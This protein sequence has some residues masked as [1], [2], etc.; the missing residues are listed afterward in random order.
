MSKELVE[1]TEQT[2]L[3][4]HE[5]APQGPTYQERL[6]ALT[7]EDRAKWDLTG[8]LPEETKSDAK[9][10]A[11]PS[12]AKEKTP[13]AKAQTEAE[14]GPADEPQQPKT[15]QERN[16]ANLQKQAREWERKA[17]AAQAQLELL[18]RE[19]AGNRPSA[20]VTKDEQAKP[21]AS[22]KPKRPRLSDFETV[23]QYETAF[24]KYEEARDTYSSQQLAERERQ[25]QATQSETQKQTTW[26]DQV[27]GAKSK[28]EDFEAVAFSTE[29][30]AS[31]ASISRLI[32]RKD[33]AE[34]AYFLGKNPDQAA[35]IAE[36]TAI[37]GIQSNEQYAQLR[38][39][40]QTN[41]RAA[42]AIARAEALADAAFDRIAENFGKPAARTTTPRPKPTSEVS[43]N[44]RGQPVGDELEDAL[45][46]Q[47]YPTYERLAN[48]RDVERFKGA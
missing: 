13:V 24:D 29:T 8:E 30:P 20:P 19:R 44:P 10:V 7:P 25:Q 45:A 5:D 42:E 9:P 37:S 21:Q 23:E 26:A 41:P 15:R 2:E 28:Y 6:D 17:I 3:Q 38:Q 4:P 35:K 31:A 18:E 40:A 33:G 32:A 47:D 48:R 46:R 43:I 34:L 11:D 16:F 12:P 1:S 27:T 39:M 22:D 36:A 14:S